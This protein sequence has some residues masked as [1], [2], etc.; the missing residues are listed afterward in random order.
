MAEETL[1]CPSCNQKV[2]VPEELLGQ[3]VQCPLCR[4]VFTAPVRGTPPAVLP[5]PTEHV[6]GADQG[7]A[8]PSVPSPPPPFSVPAAPPVYQQPV[9]APIDPGQRTAAA[10]VL[11][12]PAMFMLAVGA[13]GVVYNLFEA[14]RIRVAGPQGL[15][16]QLEDQKE[17]YARLGMQPP[18]FLSPDN[19]YVM[20]LTMLCAFLV[21]RLFMLFAGIQMLRGRGYGMAIT[22]TILSLIPLLDCPC[23][24]LSPPVAIWALVVLLRS[25]VRSLFQ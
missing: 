25:D 4:L 14:I 24:L 3:P 8:P 15:A 16:Q 22:G 5:A 7:S 17:I 10:N 12:V 21:L 6:R 23:C 20:L 2:R 11:R 9:P 1:Y 13:L 18:Q 19:M